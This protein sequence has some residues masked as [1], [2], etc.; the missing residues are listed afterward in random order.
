MADYGPL[1]YLFQGQNTTANGQQAPTYS[2]AGL[3][4]YGNGSQNG[5]LSDYSQGGTMYGSPEDNNL[6]TIL[7]RAASGQLNNGLSAFLGRYY[8]QSNAPTQYGGDGDSNTAQTQVQYN[9]DPIFQLGSLAGMDMSKYNFNQDPANRG[10][11]EGYN[12]FY[13]DLNKSLQNYTSIQGLSNQ[14]TGREEDRS[15]TK[16]MYYNDN[17]QLVPIGTPQEYMQARKGGWVRQHG[18]FIQ[19]LSMLMPAFGGWGGIAGSGT[20]GTLTA[21]GGLGLT[22]GISGA[23]GTGATNALVNSGMNAALSGS[24][25]KGFGMGLAGAGI[26]AAMNGGL[27][28]M[29]EQGGQSVTNPMANFAGAVNSS[30][31]GNSMFGPA[32]SALALGGNYMGQVMSGNGQYG[33]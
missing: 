9:S 1:G 19:A 25:L 11:S 15:A 22:S 18:D 4:V 3:N 24:G 28:K 14:W 26:G 2:A 23:I 12:Q 20:A 17:G 32:S 6:R 30:G 16:T 31:L 10:I 33:N 21:G 8:Q 5:L 7:D 27:G 29:F 13:N